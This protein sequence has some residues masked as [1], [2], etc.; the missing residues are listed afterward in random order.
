MILTINFEATGTEL[1]LVL[2]A[3][4]IAKL[5][6]TNGRAININSMLCYLNAFGTAQ[7]ILMLADHSGFN[8]KGASAA[9]PFEQ[10]SEMSESQVRGGATNPRIIRT[11]EPGSKTVF[12][13]T[14]ADI[15]P[16][17]KGFTLWPVFQYMIIGWT[18]DVDFLI[19]FDYTILDRGLNNRSQL[20]ELLA[21]K[22]QVQDP[23]IT[24]VQGKRALRRASLLLEV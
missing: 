18:A 5:F 12:R 14:T 21:N 15:A 16:Q 23:N 9:F 1:A 11:V 24:N 20:M 6:G 17:G 7:E 22:R 19:E 10:L 8:P 4:D 13:F 3:D 2:R